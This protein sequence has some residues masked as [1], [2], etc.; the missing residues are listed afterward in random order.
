MRIIKARSRVNQ[1]SDRPAKLLGALREAV[2]QAEKAGARSR[3][4]SGRHRPAAGNEA[5]TKRLRA[6]RPPEKNERE[7][8]GRYSIV[9]D[10]KP[11]DE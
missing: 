7:S 4:V 2:E 6:A 11:S 3:R 1:P 8:A 10:E 9:G 5:P